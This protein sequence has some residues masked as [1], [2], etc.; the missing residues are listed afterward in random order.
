MTPDLRTAIEHRYRIHLGPARRLSGGYECDVWRL[1][2]EQAAVVVRISPSWRTVAE[3]AWTHE[4]MRF[5]EPIVPEVVA[6]LVAGDGATL[7]V[8][9]QHPVALFPFVAGH[10]L[11]RERASLRDAAARLLARLHQALRRWPTQKLRPPPGPAAPASQPPADDPEF[12]VDPTL[13][14]WHAALATRSPALPVG[15]IHGDY[16]RANLRCVGERIVGVL[17]WDDSAVDYLLQEVA[18]A[19]WEFSKAARGDALVPDRAR[20]FLAAYRAAGGP[21]GEDETALVVP[22]IRWRLRAEVRAHLAA[23]AR[24]E[25]GDRAYMEGQVRAFHHLA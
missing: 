2:S 7:F 24:G 19:T 15:P 12:L 22:F 6:P 20:R 3:L 16:Y 5:A 13:D 14:A 8:H 23:A 21:C 18:W 9:Q 25:V 1:A 11:D 4:L 17:D 10:P